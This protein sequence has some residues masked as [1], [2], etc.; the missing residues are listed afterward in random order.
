MN[1]KLT[2]LIPTKN[3]YAYLKNLIESI[4]ISKKQEF[5]VVIQDNSDNPNLFKKYIDELNDSRIKYEHQSGY[6]SVIQNCEKGASRGRGEFLCMLGDDDGILVDE[7]LDFL[8]NVDMFDIDAIV[9]N[10]ASFNWP[11]SKHAVWSNKLSGHLFTN[12]YTYKTVIKND[13][14]QLIN[15]VTKIAGVKGVEF[16]PRIYHG[17]VR[18]SIMNQLKLLTGNFFPGPSPD[19]ANAIGVSLIVNSYL[20]YDAPL[21]ISGASVKSTAGQGSLKKHSGLINQ[22]A[23]L[24]LDTLEKWD[25]NIPEFWSASTIYAESLS[26]ALE[27]SNVQKNYLINYKFLYAWLLVYEKKYCKVT[28]SKINNKVKNLFDYLIIFYYIH[29]ILLRRFK[30]LI[31]NV[32]KYNFKKN[33]KYYTTIYDVVL[34]LKSLVITK[35]NHF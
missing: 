19:M 23:H 5:E 29:I 3:R 13:S 12:N 34:D 7:T 11:D 14:I 10:P 20:F 6:L 31:A 32:L 33:K 2:I 28:Y 22:Q 18:R 4:L 35:T 1:I 16:L 25:L 8:F 9:V 24:P 27:L 15:N 30:N 26:K 21:I 17:F